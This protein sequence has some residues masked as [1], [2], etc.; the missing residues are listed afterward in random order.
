MKLS[1]LFIY[2]RNVEINNDAMTDSFQFDP[3]PDFNNYL[4]EDKSR[5]QTATDAGFKDA[6]KDFLIGDSGGFLFNQNFKFINTHLFSEVAEFFNTHKTYTLDE[7]D[8]IPHRKFRKREEYR[9][10]YGFE[11]PCKLMADGTIQN[12]RITGEHYNFLNYTKILRLDKDHLLKSGVARK[13][14]L[15]PCF[16]DSQYWWYKSKEFSKINGFNLI[17][18]KTRRAG[19]SY[20][21]GKGAANTINLYPNLTVILAAWDK[22]YVTQGNSIAPMTLQQLEFYETQTPFK[23]GILSRDIEDIKLGY[24][25]KQNIEHGYLSRVVAV[26][27][28]NNDNAAIGKD[29]DEIKVDELG[30]MPNY[31]GFTKQTDATLKTGAFI[32]GQQIG[33]GT[34]N[35]DS[36]S[37]EVFERNFRNPARYRNMPFENVWDKASRDKVCGF[38]KP[39][40]WGLEGYDEDTLEFAMD[41]DGNSR[42]NIAIKIVEREHRVSYE[43]AE[44]FKDY[45]DFKGQYGNCPNDSFSSSIENIF[46]SPELEAHIRRVGS[47]DDFNFYRDG[48]LVEK[49]NDVEFKSNNQLLN[50]GH[51]SR[52]HE[53]ITR[54]TPSKK[55]DNYGCIRMWFAPYK[56]EGS[57]PDNL[58]RIWVD[59]FG[60]DKTKDK[61][62]NK[63]SFGGI[64]IYMNANNFSGN[65]GDML[66]ASYVGRPESQEEF[67]K[68]VALLCKYYNAKVMVESDRGTTINNFKRWRLENMLVVEPTIAWDASLQGS[69]GRNYGISMGAGASNRRLKGIQY[70]YEWL[71]SV[72]GVDDVGNKIY[73]FHYIYDIGLLREIKKWNINGNFDRISTMLVG[74]YDTKELLYNAVTPTNPAAKKNRG[75]SILNRPW[76]S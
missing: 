44:D 67:D 60:I 42:Y 57:I 59:P 35:S 3:C 75:T 43:T 37:A 66:V 16:F 22:K 39:Y 71:Y 64:Y 68:I 17:V 2:S 40:W 45:I 56:K 30:N 49:G 31:D 19:F 65:Q 6:D 55:E 73:T 15:F 36:Q 52:V 25:D 10:K 48:I 28:R 5:Y 29:A 34:I 23:R 70:L 13:R 61:V 47:T 32:T 54:L 38:Y 58:Y 74:M 14:L 41:N 9:R 72:R 7:V 12:L 20:M 8:S 46:T 24:K 11:A 1:S 4:Q 33:F 69:T 27:T 63:N 62:T 76:F 26:S 21:E 18:C 53:F 50:D 51:T